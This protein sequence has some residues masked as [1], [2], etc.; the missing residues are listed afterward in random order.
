MLSVGFGNAHYKVFE[1]HKKV[2]IA[3]LISR[4]KKFLQFFRYLVNFRVKRETTGGP[5]LR[6]MKCEIFKYIFEFWRQKWR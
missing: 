3:K 2:L 1:K 6:Q 5:S 4:K